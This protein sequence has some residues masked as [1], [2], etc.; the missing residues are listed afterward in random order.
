MAETST[1][2][3]PHNMSISKT[4]SQSSSPYLC[5]LLI[6][7]TLG[8][9]NISVQ[10]QTA[11]SFTLEDC[12]ERAK[13]YSIQARQGLIAVQIEE[14][15]RKEAQQ[16]ILPNLNAGAS[17]VNN[18]GLFID[19]FTNVIQRQVRIQNYSGNLSSS[20][21]VF[22]G[23]ANHNNIKRSQVNVRAAQ[24]NYE[25]AINDLQLM[26]S[27]AFVGVLFAEELLRVAEQQVQITAIQVN[28][29]I[30]EVEAGTRPQGDLFDIQ[31]QLAREEQ[32]Q[33]T[34]ENNLRSAKLA[35]AQLMLWDDYESLNLSY[36]DFEL[37][38]PG[39]LALSTQQIYEK[40][41]GNQPQIE[42]D[43][44][45]LQSAQLGKNIATASYYPS[46]RL[47]GSMSTGASDRISDD[48][49]K[50][51]DENL[52]ENLV[53]SMNIPI[54]NRR[55]VTSS[56]NRAQLNVMN[57]ELQLKQSKNQLLQQIQSAY[58]DAKAAYNKYRADEKTVNSLKTA[59]NYTEE[60]YKVGLI[61][62]YEYNLSKNQLT[63]AESEMVR[64]KFD[65]LF[66]LMVLDFYYNQ[67][68]E[69]Q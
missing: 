4:I 67:K 11:G 41:L 60:R 14:E 40:A 52:G 27:N 58:N 21:P 15:N 25:A 61:N 17:W 22:Q 38:S 24:K 30:N 57:A 19:P 39:L 37:E 28:R 66:K 45:N 59:F 69:L 42:R 26:V 56:V 2:T 64:D 44:L 23:L 1:S 68:I 29:V 51:F 12:I 62:A 49:G 3:N 7:F 53:L 46:I 32:N 36:P 65:A 18:W 8:I 6:L 55:Q 33:I 9:G 35:L 43:A 50:Q 47:S 5:G 34:T 48:F 63:A 10:A 54:Y 16:S 31:A 20:V 13:D